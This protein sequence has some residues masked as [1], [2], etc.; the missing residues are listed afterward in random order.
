MGTQAE[1]LRTAREWST[2]QPSTPYTIGLE[3]EVMLLDPEDWTLARGP[4]LL[5]LSAH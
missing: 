2:W 1:Q 5:G 3:E 4:Q